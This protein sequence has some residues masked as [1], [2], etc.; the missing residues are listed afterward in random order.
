MTARFSGSSVNETHNVCTERKLRLLVVDD[1][2]DVCAILTVALGTA[3]GCEVR[4]ADDAKSALLALDAEETPFDGIFLDI[5]M[6]ETTGIE[7][8]EIIRGTPGYS[9]V[10]IIML[11]AM[12]ERCYLRD[13]FAKGA[14]DYITKPFA[15]DDLGR[16]LAKQRADR[17]RRKQFKEIS[18]GSGKDW[19]KPDRE[20]IRSLEDAVKIQG[21]ERCVGREAFQAY[22][23]QSHAR[24]T[25]PV[26]VR[27]IKIAK[28][29]DLF[30]QLPN[31]EYQATVQRIAGMLSLLTK[32][33]QD[34][35]T[36]FGNGIFL[37][38]SIGTSSL[39]QVSLSAALERD[40]G[41]TRL[42]DHN[43]S[44]HLILGSTV[45]VN[46][47]TKT[48]AVLM[49]KTAIEAVEAVEKSMSSWGTFR[50]WMS[51]RMSIG[52]ERSRMDQTAYQQILDDFIEAG[53][54]GWK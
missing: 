33:T 45:V 15:L 41:M 12:T 17:Q 7:L 32:R 38:S 23:L 8:C 47:E 53:E 16:K 3:S 6:P 28:V 31:G 43:V 46:G 14:N 29:Y 50:E 49:L 5:Q 54:I 1:E 4:V 13:A 26:S 21:V 24:F 40:D 34:V 9:D 52:R 37:S 25:T 19:R 10:P 27:A 2:P 22:I 48:D 20:I 11:T 18:A 44:L 30:S 35:F 36:Y 42:A 51:Q 39:D